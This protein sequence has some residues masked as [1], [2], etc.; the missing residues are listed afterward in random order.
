M[1]HDALG[2][3]IK[4]NYE[5]P[6]RRYLT[7]RVP[8]VIRVDGRAF[9]TL[10]KEHFK[11]PFDTK[12]IEAMQLAAMQTAAEIQGFKMGFVQSDEVSFVLTD[13]DDVATEGWFGYCQNKM[14]SIAAARMTFCFARCLRLMNINTD[15]EFD[16]RAF[17][18]PEAEV[19]NYFLWRAKD[20]YRNSVSM[21][22]R[23]KYSHSEMH[24]KKIRDMHEML[25]AVGR[26]W[27]T[28]LGDEEKNGTFILSDF[29]AR[30]DIKPHFQEVDKLW[31]SVN[32]TTRETREESCPGLESDPNLCLTTD[33]SM[34]SEQAENENDLESNTT[35]SGSRS[36]I[37]GDGT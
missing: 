18:V 8:V 21:Y 37:P 34:S 28:D 11:R 29:Q 2:D 23:A 25:H 15:V 12:F 7:R 35:P 5:L 13:Y 14:E 32:P 9:H 1:K 26:N 31:L 20:W 16:A 3:R 33:P 10:T 30:S 6:A 22:T 17:N 19:T 4:R 36:G 27:S 24:G